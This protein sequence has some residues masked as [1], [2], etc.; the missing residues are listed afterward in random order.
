MSNPCT[1][2]LQL[3]NLG[4]RALALSN[5][6]TPKAARGNEC[7]G[8]LP[9]RDGMYK[10]LLRIEN[11]QESLPEEIINYCVINFMKKVFNAMFIKD[12]D[13]PDTLLAPDE[14]QVLLEGLCDRFGS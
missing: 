3:V 7:A 4:V 2:G 1:R 13:L 6:A 8:L 10:D 9:S 11:A 14:L 12:V 5:G